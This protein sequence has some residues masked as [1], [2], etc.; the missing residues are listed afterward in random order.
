VE[1]KLKEA[2]KK[3]AGNDK[4]L[5]VSIESVWGSTL[6]HLDDLPYNPR[7]YLPHIYGKFREKQANVR[8]R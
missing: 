2:L 6:H 8:V 3:A 4:N 7:E 1:Q 5:N